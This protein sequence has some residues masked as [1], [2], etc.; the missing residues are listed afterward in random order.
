M[1]DTILYWTDC[2]SYKRTS[3]PNTIDVI[4]FDINKHDAHKTNKIYIKLRRL[5]LQ[6]RKPTS[7]AQILM[8]HP[9]PTR[10]TNLK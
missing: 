8:V 1:G 4:L 5:T 6:R 2:K 7:L 3:Y 9:T 10:K